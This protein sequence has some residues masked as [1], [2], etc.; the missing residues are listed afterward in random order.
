MSPTGVPDDDAKRRFQRL[1]AVHFAEAD[2]AKFLWQT[3]N[4]YLA[5]TERALLGCAGI[6]PTDRLLEIGCG[7]GGNLELLATPPGRTVGVDF[8]ERKVRWAA[9]HVGRARFVCADARRLP[10]R[11]GAFDIVLCRDVLHHVADKGTVIEEMIRVCGAAGRLAVI[12][13]NGRSPIMWLLG[14][15]VPAERDLMRNSLPRLK[16]LLE[17]R[18][19]ANGGVHWAQPFPLGRALFHYRWGLPRLAGRL[20]PLM[21]GLERRLGRFIPS[22]YWAYIV[23]TAIKRAT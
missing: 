18:S 19:L 3:T 15:L 11:D 14:A 6:R 22:G 4:A 16:P 9:R 20:G 23:L 7:E 17:R 13:P 2:T 5:G 1:Q 8:S 10:F 21:L 12:E